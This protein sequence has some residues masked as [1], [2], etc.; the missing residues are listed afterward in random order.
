LSIHAYPKILLP[1]SFPQ[2]FAAVAE[3]RSRIEATHCGYTTPKLE[4]RNRYR[5]VVISFL[6]TFHILNECGID[7]TE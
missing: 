2:M 4:T 3:A 5:M 1:L 7:S 6:S